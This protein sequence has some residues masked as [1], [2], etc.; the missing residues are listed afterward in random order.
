LTSVNGIIGASLKFEDIESAFIQAC[1]HADLG[2]F[3]QGDVILLARDAGYDMRT[4]CREWESIAKVSR[5]T[6]YNRA[7]TAAVF[8]PTMREDRPGLWSL[9]MA[10][11]AG[12]DL[13]DS[14]TYIAAYTR[15]NMALKEGWTLSQLKSAIA[16]ER[17]KADNLAL[18]QLCRGTECRAVECD[19]K[20][21]TLLLDPS[22][23]ATIP[24]NEPLVV[25]LFHVQA[26]A[27][28]ENAA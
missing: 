20:R 11:C 28:M 23:A 2:L 18:V 10:A 17:G 27:Q 25:S 6:L 14:E 16:S 12:V 9:Y 5:R 13:D 24:L 3:A 7:K 22:I 1:E 4:L 21:I 26:V 8:P 15:M 19:G